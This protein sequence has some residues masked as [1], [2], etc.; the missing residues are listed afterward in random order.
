MKLLQRYRVYW[1]EY[2]CDG[3]AQSRSR[4]V[5][6]E[7]SLHAIYLVKL[8]GGFSYKAYRTEENNG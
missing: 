8:K 5:W 4:A 7:N 3:K 6:A 1:L 2:D